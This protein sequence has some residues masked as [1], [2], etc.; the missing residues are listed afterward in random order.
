MSP[1]AT[2]SVTYVLPAGSTVTQQLK[3]PALVLGSPASA[4]DGSYQRLIE[5]LEKTRSVEK[6]MVDRLVEGATTLVP[7]SYGAIYAVLGLSDFNALQ[8]K[9]PSLLT[10]LLSGLSTHGTLHV[11]H[12]SSVPSSLRT[13]LERAGFEI[14]TEEDDTG[15]LIAQKFRKPSASTSTSSST[16]TYSAPVS[17]PASVP[18]NRPAAVS[19]PLR[20]GAADAARRSNKKAVWTLTTPAP[21]T[22]TID[23]E[24]LLTDADRARPEPCAPPAGSGPRRRKACKGCTCGLAELEA[25]EERNA[26][27]VMID[28]AP[29]GGA[30]EVKA[31]E[32]ERLLKAAA[33]APK[34]TSSCG[35]C[36][37]GDAFR[38]DG[39]PYRGLPA[40]KPGEKVEISF[41]D[42]I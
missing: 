32:R 4:Q 38:C 29:N 36:A 41:D 14:L 26:T 34:M 11:A 25:E 31:A 16:T 35:N 3:A 13:D 40:F 39:C 24:A 30:R 27:V 18:L 6:L 20:R 9:L 12:A 8:T 22:P 2:E 23:A 10:Q 37:L 19:L 28:G 1:V 33:A 15:A 17:T 7:A 21:G 42:D 5:E